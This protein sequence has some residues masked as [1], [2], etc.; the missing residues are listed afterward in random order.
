MTTRLCIMF[1]LQ[2][3]TLALH[4]DSNNNNDNSNMMDCQNLVNN[5]ISLN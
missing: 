2:L 5:S 1:L 4:N 3:S